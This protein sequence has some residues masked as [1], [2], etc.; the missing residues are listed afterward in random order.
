MKWPATRGS[1][2]GIATRLLLAQGLVVTC[3]AITAAGVAAIVGPPLFHHHLLMAGERPNTPELRHI[4]RA[5]TSANTIALG[6]AVLIALIAAIAVTWYLSRRLTRPVVQLA[7]VAERISYGDYSAR[8]TPAAA[9]PELASLTGTFNQVAERLQHTESTRHRLL[10]D[11]A[12]ELRTPIATLEA[13]LDGLDDGVTGWGPEPARV[14]RD[15]ITR[16]HRLAE[17]LNDVSRAEEGE[18]GL[19][20]ERT[21]VQL[22]VQAAVESL[23]PRYVGKGVQLRSAISDRADA[24]VLVDFQRFAQALTNVLINALRHTPP[25]GGVTVQTTIDT[26]SIRIAVIDTGDGIPADQLPHI[27]ERF[28]RGRLARDRDSTGSGIGLTI[29]R[30]IARAHHGT[31]TADSDGP[32]AGARFTFTLPRRLHR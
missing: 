32:G 30:V 5:Y 2:P 3:G 18:L 7:A 20:L 26:G 12:H 4:E 27:F 25:G 28:Y 19:D 10:A 17:D 14:F 21:P 23:R 9:G 22:V 1:G 16:L 6:M 13:Y 24:E 11:L 15:Q 8:A 29:S 31:L